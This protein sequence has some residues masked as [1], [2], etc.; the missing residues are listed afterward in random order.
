MLYEETVPE[1]ATRTQA[2][3]G[4]YLWEIPGAAIAVDLD[5]AVIDDLLPEVMRA[6]AAVPKR[7]AEV[8][9][10]LLG[11]VEPSAGPDRPTLVRVNS[12]EL[13]PC[14]YAR[15]PS[16]LLTEEESAAFEQ[17][18]ER[19]QAEASQHSSVVGYFRSHT[20]PGLSLSPEDL[21]LLKR[22]F[23]NS[24]DIALL[25]RPFA[26]QPTQAGFFFREQ[27]AFQEESPL[28][29][30][31]SHLEPAADT[32]PEPEA[33]PASSPPPKRKRYRGS[34]RRL[35]PLPDEEELAPSP[36][37]EEKPI[38]PQFEPQTQLEKTTPELRSRSLVSL[39]VAIAFL[40]LLVGAVAGFEVWQILRGRIPIA[41]PR[42]FS[43]A[44]HVAPD[45]DGLA[46]RWDPAAPA[47]R[48]AKSGVLQIEDGGYSETVDLDSAHLRNSGLLYR[49]SS[50]S[51]RFRLTVYEGARASVTE[52][53]DW[54]R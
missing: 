42:E 33:A 13:V 43:L 29:F 8:G 14:T 46:V 39:W 10:L 1:M 6:F 45:G 27:G 53:V 22:H 25:I 50:S 2:L 11:V 9:G 30:P 31:F 18:R 36:A 48:N 35:I 3:P 26:T 4:G 38:E 15:G 23:P 16:Y 37:A 12:F 40:F 32:E 21:D 41:A 34:P 24:F 49:N 44:L 51:V 47:I 54:V 20:R 17:A 19:R 5:L 28:V 7:G 52:T